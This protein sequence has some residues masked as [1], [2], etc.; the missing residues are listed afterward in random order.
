MCVCFFILEKVKSVHRE[1]SLIV[2]RADV[3]QPGI[4]Q[5]P[6]FRVGGSASEVQSL[7]RFLG[8][9]FLVESSL[10]YKF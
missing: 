10:F 2:F 6:L 3:T 1:R 7:E 9:D 5:E 4:L 8:S